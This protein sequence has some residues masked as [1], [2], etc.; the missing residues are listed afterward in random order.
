METTFLFVVLLLSADNLSPGTAVITT[1]PRNILLR[2]FYQK[3]ENKVIYQYI[4]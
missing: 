4:S 3:S 1:D 2:H